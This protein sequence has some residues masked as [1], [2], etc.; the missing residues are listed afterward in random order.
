MESREVLATNLKSLMRSANIRSQAELA[1]LTGISQ[2]QIGNIINRKK[3]A[4]IDTL[5]R[6]AKGFEC[7]SW[8]L[9]APVSVVENFDSA[10][11]AALMHCYIHLPHDGQKT[12][13]DMTYHLYESTGRNYF[14]RS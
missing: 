5:E 1:N 14:S 3:A 9:L 11:F 8:L 10:D 6:L 7:D 4:S 2:T 13:W 12:I